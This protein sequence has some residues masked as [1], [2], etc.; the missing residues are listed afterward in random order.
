MPVIVRKRLICALPELAGR[1]AA[2]FWFLV[3]PKRF[4]CVGHVYAPDS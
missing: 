3:L 1:H 4:D 2:E